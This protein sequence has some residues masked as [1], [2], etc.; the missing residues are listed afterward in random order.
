MV[1]SAIS[2]RVAPVGSALH[3]LPAR[4]RLELLSCFALVR[5]AL[6][7]DL[8][9]PP[10]TDDDSA[11]VRA[12]IC[13]RLT[14]IRILRT[15]PNT[16]HQ[17]TAELS[18]LG[19][20]QVA[21]RL[22]PSDALVSRLQRIDV[23]AAEWVRTPE[24]MRHWVQ[25]LALLDVALLL[26]LFSTDHGASGDSDLVRR[27]VDGLLDGVEEVLGTAPP[28]EPAELAVPRPSEFVRL[29][30]DAF[31]E[32]IELAHDI[33]ELAGRWWPEDPDIGAARRLFAPP[34]VKPHPSHSDRHARRCNRDWV[35]AHEHEYAGEWLVV[36]D[37]V[38]RGHGGDLGEVVKALGG[39]PPGALV[40]RAG[41]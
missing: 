25:H 3:R 4:D 31:A 19:E 20:A 29:A 22:D 18:A 15:H 5:L 12:A 40:V 7:R 6:D 33:V 9:D 23:R 17:L 30:H 41:A 1:A 24:A 13:A 16:E 34:V 36:N 8:D 39:L 2:W 21:Q 14:L 27:G 37:G 10:S 38:L 32:S 35:R 11:A 28:V 26:L